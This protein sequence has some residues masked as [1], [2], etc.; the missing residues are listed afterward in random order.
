MK[1]EV[2]EKIRTT[3]PLGIRFWDVAT[4][5]QVTSGLSVT[6]RPEQQPR[7]LIAAQRTSGGIYAFHHLPG[8]RDVANMNTDL[9]LDEPFA[10]TRRYIVR[11]EDSL[12]RYLPVAFV[13]SAPFAGIFPFG[14][15]EQSPPAS[16]GFDLFSRATR[17]A[18][19]AFAEVRADLWDRDRDAPATHAVLEVR[20]EPGSLYHGISDADG[21]VVVYFPYPPVTVSLSGSPQIGTKIALSEQTWQVQISLRYA[22]NL[23][24]SFTGIA[25]PNFRTVLEQTAGELFPNGLGG[26]VGDFAQSITFGRPAIL[27]SN[28]G[29]TLL[30]SSGGSPP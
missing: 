19:A 2:L 25:E 30:V 27:R 13:V 11:V 5:Q 29:S 10:L 12:G 20:T 7:P 22:P 8:L 24:T 16:R 23:V 15:G 3:T 18:P 6:A 21:K 14:T 1:V 4:E 9:Q 28:G 26:A 17:Q